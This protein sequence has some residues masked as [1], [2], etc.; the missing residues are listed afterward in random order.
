MWRRPARWHAR[1]PSLGRTRFWGP[2]H[3]VPP[4]K[5]AAWGKWG[6]APQTGCTTH[7]MASWNGVLRRRFWNQREPPRRDIVRIVR[8]PS[9]R[10]GR[11]VAG[12]GGGVDQMCAL[13]HEPRAA[14]F[15]Y[16]P[17]SIR[18]DRRS[19]RSARDTWP[20]SLAMLVRA[21]PDAFARDCRVSL[22]RS[23]RPTKMVTIKL[24]WCACDSGR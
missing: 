13:G 19:G 11:R 1:V 24:F 5:S 12:I 2:Y 8:N 9:A 6:Q 15:L 22:K 16:A 18:P 21:R 23:T 20:G 17:V 3:S 4:I 14:F 10:G 7:G